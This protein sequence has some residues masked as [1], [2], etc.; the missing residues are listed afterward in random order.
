MA[1][2]EMKS[3]ELRLEVTDEKRRNGKLEKEIDIL[4]AVIKEL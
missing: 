3:A 4:R 2:R 1:V